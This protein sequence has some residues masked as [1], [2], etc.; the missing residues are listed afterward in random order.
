MHFVPLLSDMVIHVSCAIIFIRKTVLNSL[1]N[2]TCV[3][4]ALQD[5]KIPVCLEREKNI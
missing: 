4:N 1:L 2:P 3:D 5:Q